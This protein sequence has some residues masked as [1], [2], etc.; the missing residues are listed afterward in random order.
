MAET[1][2]NIHDV[3]RFKII[4]KQKSLVD[5]IIGDPFQEYENYLSKD[6]VEDQNLDFVVNI[7]D[8][9]ERRRDTYILDDEYYVNEGYIYTSDSYKIAKWDIEVI[10]SD[11]RCI[12]NIAPNVAAKLFISGF[13]I[14][15]VIQ[16]VLTQKGYSIVHSSAVSKC[17]RSHLFSGRG[18]SGKTSIAIHLISSDQGFDYMGD[19]FVLI[20]DGHSLPYFTPL[21][22]FNYNVNSFLLQKFS[23][24]QKLN[25]KFKGWIYRVT[26]GYAKFF[27]KLNPLSIIPNVS[28]RQS[29]VST[30][31]IIIPKNGDTEFNLKPLSKNDAVKHITNNLMMDSWFIP[32]YFVQYGYMFPD[33]GYS[34]FWDKYH[35]NL[36]INLPESIKFYRVEVPKTMRWNDVVSNLREGDEND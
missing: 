13:F 15:F 30:V 25:F 28:S 6:I 10:E 2:Y 3:V 18:G 23:R 12:V 11:R 16:Y 35:Q 17:G 20:K 36:M 14:D 24:V 27:T 31:T 29:E 7:V 33:S 34:R 9:I 5:R 8:N 1:Y 26:G 4:D 19:D 22:L 21:N 32:K